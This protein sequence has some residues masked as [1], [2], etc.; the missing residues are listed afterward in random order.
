MKNLTDIAK[1]HEFGSGTLLRWYGVKRT[2]RKKEDD[3]YDLLL[4][5]ANDIK[6]NTWAL[7][8]CTHGSSHNG[9]MYVVFNCKSRLFMTADFLKDHFENEEVY[10]LT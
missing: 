9:H 4:F 5:D 3:Y 7:I 1:D 2:N 8:N 10:V 6:K